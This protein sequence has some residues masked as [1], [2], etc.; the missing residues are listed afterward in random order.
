[1]YSIH[2]ETLVSFVKSNVTGG[3]GDV[4]KLRV[5]RTGC[6]TN[7]TRCKVHT[8][9]T[10]AEKGMCGSVCCVH[11]CMCVYIYLMNINCYICICEHACYMIHVCFCV[12]VCACMPHVYMHVTVCVMYYRI[13]IY[14]Y[15]YDV[16]LTTATMVIYIYI[17]PF[18]NKLS[19]KTDLT[20]VSLYVPL[21]LAVGFEISSPASQS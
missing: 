16:Y 9:S 17:S 12:H 3:E 1:M 11:V 7:K 4:V 10:T 19:S 5:K 2:I 21:N 8:E 13:Y 20:R 6:I 18:E 15:I 14:I